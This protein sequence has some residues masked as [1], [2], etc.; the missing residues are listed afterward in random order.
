MDDLARL[1]VS[2]QAPDSLLHAHWVPGQVVVEHP[3]AGLEVQSIGADLARA[4]HD[5]ARPAPEARHSATALPGAHRAVELENAQRS[6]LD[7]EAVQAL[8][9]VVDRSC[10]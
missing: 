2:V 5:R 7:P 8:G 9:E 1:A 10:E 4:P 6:S 3:R